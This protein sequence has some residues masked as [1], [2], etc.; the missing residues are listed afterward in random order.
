MYESSAYGFQ[1]AEENHKKN[2]ESYAQKLFDL[3]IKELG[4]TIKCDTRH[5]YNV[6]VFEGIVEASKESK[7]DAILMASHKRTGLKSLFMGSDTSAVIKHTKLP[8]LVI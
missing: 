2:C 5:L 4:Q 7:V 8:V 6:N 3:A 1:V